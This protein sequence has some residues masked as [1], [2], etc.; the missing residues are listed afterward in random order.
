M[1]HKKSWRLALLIG[2][3]RHRAL[4]TR[5]IV[6]LLGVSRVTAWRYLQEVN[7][8][9]VGWQKA[10]RVRKLSRY[11]HSRKAFTTRQA[12]ASVGVSMWTM[13]RYL[14]EGCERGW[15]V[16]RNENG[17]WIVGEHRPRYGL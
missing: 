8:P 1:D 2:A 13:R 7:N 10:V 16:V 14:R 3:H 17:L 4:S 11:A 12:A 6:L 15:L 5:D 9:S